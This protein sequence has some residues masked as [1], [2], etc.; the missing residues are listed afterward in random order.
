MSKKPVKTEEEEAAP[1]LSPSWDEALNPKRD[2]AEP[3]SDAEKQE[4]AVAD[5][6][7]QAL[8][9]G[10]PSVVPEPKVTEEKETVQKD[11]EPP[12][13]DEKPTDT[14]P[15]KTDDE[16]PITLSKEQFE[17]LQAAAAFVKQLQSG[18][19]ELIAGLHQTTEQKLEEL[20]QKL[21][22]KIGTLNSLIQKKGEP[23]KLTREQFKR[24][25]ALYDPEMIDALVEDLSGIVLQP[26]F[27]QEELTKTISESLQANL[28]ES[29]KGKV[30]SPDELQQTVV[31]MSDFV[32]EQLLNY[33]SPGWQKKIADKSY[34]EFID[35]LPAGKAKEIEASNDP[36]VLAQTIKDYDAW[37]AAKTQQDTQKQAEKNEKKQALE[38]AQQPKGGGSPP[39]KLNKTD[40]E[41]AAEAAFNALQQAVAS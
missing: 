8:A 26:Q 12:A 17:E 11:D 33:A 37:L 14:P 36:A 29:L 5:A 28:M 19:G 13:G 34:D 21:T 6:A 32:N 1:V 23:A 31:A 10:E 40:E 39:T 2:D 25:S 16:P 38:K 20:N 24:L 41:A 7:F 9:G 27:N 4:L 3:M 18:E 35:A 22:G 30:V 15:A